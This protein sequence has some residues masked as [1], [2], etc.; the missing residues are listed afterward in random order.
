MYIADDE[1]IKRS[2]SG[3]IEA[4]EELVLRYEK[5]VYTIAYRYMGNREDA[6]DLAQ[7]AL[8]KVY[9][10]LKKFRGESSFSTWLYRIVANVCRDALRKRAGKKEASLDSP[11]STSEGELK[12]EVEDT[13]PTP[14]IL[15]EQREQADYIQEMISRLDPKYRVVI[16][17]REIQGFTYE[18]IASQLG[19]SLGTVKSRLSRARKILRDSIV[20]DGELYAVYSRLEGQKEGS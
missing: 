19:C 15:L 6:S 3:E 10:N 2:K 16:V 5:R 9:K 14:D 17:M 20:E 7:E 8:I 13:S 11:I 1:F 18:E 12:R 4:F